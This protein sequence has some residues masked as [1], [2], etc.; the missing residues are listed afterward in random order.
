MSQFLSKT[1]KEY[2]EQAAS[3]L[4]GKM[5]P[6]VL[7]TLVYFLISAVTSIVDGHPSTTSWVWSLVTTLVIIFVEMPLAFSYT[8]AFMPL[9]R[10]GEHKDFMEKMFSVFSNG[11]YVRALCVSLLTGVYIFLWMLLLIIPGIIKAY[12]YAM[13]YYIAKDHPEMSAEE[14]VHE[15]R[16]MMQ[17]HKGKL[18]LL[19]LSYIGWIL[20]G[21]LTLGILM[22]WVEPKIATAHVHFYEDL[23]AYKAEQPVEAVKQ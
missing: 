10:N 4:V 15:S 6:I 11:N 22:L 16:M 13:T 3:T 2:R 12:S 9:V 18:F 17:G 1:S 14:C 21:C 23:K 20:L 8:T 5:T 7:A 19:D